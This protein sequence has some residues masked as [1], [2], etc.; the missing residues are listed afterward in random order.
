[1]ETLQEYKSENIKVAK[2]MVPLGLSQSGT[3]FYIEQL[4]ECGL[5]QNLLSILVE[6]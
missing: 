5:Y 1:M 2:S 6:S 4:F 3:C